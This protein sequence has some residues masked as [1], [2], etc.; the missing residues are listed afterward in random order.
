[1]AVA[2]SNGSNLA[3]AVDEDL[4]LRVQIHTLFPLEPRFW[5]Y[6]LTEVDCTMCVAVVLSYA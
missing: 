4:R 3:N 5:L 1:M 6:G 2:K